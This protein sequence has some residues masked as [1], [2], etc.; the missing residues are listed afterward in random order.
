MTDRKTKNILIIRLGALGDI[1]HCLP[2]VAHLRKHDSDVVVYWLTSPLYKD[3]LQSSGLVDHVWCWRPKDGWKQLF[4]TYK[5]L[6][7]SL[8]DTVINLHPSFK[9]RLLTFLLKPKAVEVY[10]KQKLRKKGMA[11]RR[12]TRLH[13]VEDFSRPFIKRFKLPAKSLSPLL[14]PAEN[15]LGSFNAN[16]ERIFE[17]DN[18][19]PV[20][21]ESCLKTV[22][23]IPGVG[24]KRSNRAWPEWMVVQLIQQ[25]L[26]LSRYRV[27]LV[28]GQD[29]VPL[30]QSISD[31]IQPSERF[32]NQ[33][34]Q[35]SI[36]E[37]ARLLSHCAVV[38]GGDTGPLHLATATGIPVIALYGP[39]SGSRTGPYGNQPITLLQPEEALACWPCELPVCPYRDDEHLACL[40]HIEVETVLEA[41]KTQA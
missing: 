12:I 29:E 35:C 2:S 10:H 22:A 17:D 19:E 8:F 6:Q 31:S 11:Q 18:L 16:G 37:T 32:L 27:V 33:V 30:A 4:K 39:T 36:L 34:G 14:I 23:I 41:I 5:I 25:L 24:A 38:V 40:K 13:A 28:G 7:P 20:Q 15:F 21:K 9:T 26:Q 3:I 1:L